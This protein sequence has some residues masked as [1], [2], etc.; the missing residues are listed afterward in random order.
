[1]NYYNPIPIVEDYNSTEPLQK[2]GK[3][4]GW[5]TTEETSWTKYLMNLLKFDEGTLYNEGNLCCSIDIP[6]IEIKVFKYIYKYITWTE[7]LIP[8]YILYLKIISSKVSIQNMVW[9]T[10]SLIIIWYFSDG[11][12]DQNMYYI[13]SCGI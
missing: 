6:V 5:F 4:A 3:G 2:G 9:N 12:Y 11:D 13:C 1:M 10:T 8:V 7:K